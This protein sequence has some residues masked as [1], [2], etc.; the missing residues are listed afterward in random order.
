MARTKKTPASE[1]E[2]TTQPE[3]EASKAEPDARGAEPEQYPP[4]HAF[5]QPRKTNAT[6]FGDD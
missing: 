3:A 6:A 4:G 1:T 2:P 5:H